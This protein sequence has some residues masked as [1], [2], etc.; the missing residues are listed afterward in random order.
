MAGLDG[1]FQNANW[2]LPSFHF[3]VKIGDEEW[4]FQDVSGLSSSVEILKYRHGKSKNFW[5]SK[6]PGMVSFEAAS[7]KK[8]VFSGDTKIFEW[9]KKSYTS[10]GERKT[11]IISLLNERH[12]PE[13]IW[14]LSN[15]FPTNISLPS[16][17]AENSAVA[18]EEMKLEYEELT[19]EVAPKDLLDTL[20]NLL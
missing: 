13:I 6:M 4:Y 16:L 12:K 17:S 7:L 19:I 8:G 2:P 15:A 18:I 5:V 20:L 11:V 14:T 3:E 1:L 9:Y 10:K